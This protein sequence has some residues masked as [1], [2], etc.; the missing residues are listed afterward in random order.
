MKSGR[1]RSTPQRASWDSLFLP[2]ACGA[3]HK[4]P[5]ISIGATFPVLGLQGRSTSLNSPLLSES[6]NQCFCVGDTALDKSLKEFLVGTL[7]FEEL[8]QG[9][10]HILSYQMCAVSHLDWA[11]P[12]LFLST[13]CL[14]L[15]VLPAALP[16]LQ[17]ICVWI[18]FLC[19]GHLRHNCFHKS[20][21][22][23]TS[24]LYLQCFHEV[25][26]A[27]RHHNNNVH[28]CWPHSSKLCRKGDLCLCS[29]HICFILGQGSRVHLPPTS[30]ASPSW[31]T[32]LLR[33][34]LS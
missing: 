29:P 10:P 27:R 5:S 17:P 33:F 13:I 12:C 19:W 31:D 11:S 4:A 28:V 34:L 20:S 8:Q 26:N 18:V 21:P 14:W 1:Q 3:T 30:C 7:G 22:Q 23:I 6:C 9:G 2:L 32:E 25:S 16:W 24:G 15:R